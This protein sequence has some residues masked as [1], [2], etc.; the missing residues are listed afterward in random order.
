MNMRCVFQERIGEINSAPL[1]L[2]VKNNPA[3][4]AEGIVGVSDG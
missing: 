4:T 3:E 2:Y 1:R